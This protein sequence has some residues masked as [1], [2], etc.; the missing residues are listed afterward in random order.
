MIC[1]SANPLM[2][3]GASAAP[4]EL[5]ECHSTAMHY[6]RQLQFPTMF[7]GGGSTTPPGKR[8]S[9]NV[10]LIRRY[11]SAAVNLLKPQQYSPHRRF[12]RGVA[13]P[14][15][16]ATFSTMCADPMEL[17]GLN[18]A[19]PSAVCPAF[20]IPAFVSPGLRCQASRRVAPGVRGGAA[21]NRLG[22]I[23]YR[24]K[25]VGS[26]PT[27]PSAFLLLFCWGSM[28]QIHV[29]FMQLSSQSAPGADHEDQGEAAT[30][31]AALLRTTRRPPVPGRH[32]VRQRE[33]RR[34]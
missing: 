11:R 22:P 28:L 23:P 18:L 9:V 20:A 15:W 26:G 19:I 1:Y 16:C 34:V 31:Q 27:I 17:L 2:C 24:R 13:N 10:I 8:C 7:A 3:D 32:R 14:S 4:L 5:T 6:S 30:A 25:L 21:P 33:C 29:P 12:R